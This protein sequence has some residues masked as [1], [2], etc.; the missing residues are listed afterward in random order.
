MILPQAN[1]A[2]MSVRYHS[3]GPREGEKVMIALSPLCYVSMDK[4]VFRCFVCLFVCL[5]A[6]FKSL[7]TFTTVNPLI[8]FGARVIPAT[9]LFTLKGKRTHNRN[10]L[11]RAKKCTEWKFGR[12]SSTGGAARRHCDRLTINRIYVLT[13]LNVNST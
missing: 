4:S 1:D 8:L 6:Y 3:R 12:D 11:G 5:P 7:K 13:N 10:T 2:I 9:S